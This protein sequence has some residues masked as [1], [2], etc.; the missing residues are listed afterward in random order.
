[1]ATFQS[2]STPHNGRVY[3]KK[4][5]D[6]MLSTRTMNKALFDLRIVPKELAS[7][8]EVELDDGFVLAKSENIKNLNHRF[9]EA[10]LLRKINEQRPDIVCAANSTIIDEVPLSNIIFNINNPYVPDIMETDICYCEPCTKY[11]LN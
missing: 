6:S 8:V 4:A 1:M 5:I 3:S 2:I 7:V 10:Y 9:G 11:I